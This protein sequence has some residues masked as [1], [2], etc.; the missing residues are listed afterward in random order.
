[1]HV[2]VSGRRRAA[3]MAPT[4]L[5]VRACPPAICLANSVVFSDTGWPCPA[6]KER[7]PSAE[8]QIEAGVMAAC[9]ENTNPPPFCEAR[10]KPPDGVLIVYSPG[11]IGAGVH[12]P[13]CQPGGI[14]KMPAVANGNGGP[15]L[16]PPSRG[17]PI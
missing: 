3:A 7:P 2:N 10:R 9:T 4:A 12:I 15:V 5:T 16:G 14:R 17:V 11:P 1:M 8:Y 6:E 13:L